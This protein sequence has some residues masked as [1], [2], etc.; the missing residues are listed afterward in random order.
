MVTMTDFYVGQLLDA[1]ELLDLADSTIVVF[2]SDHGFQLNEHGG[3]W[4]KTVQFEE[5]TRVPLLVRLPGGGQAGEVAAGL[6]ELVDLYP[7]LVE[8]CNLPAPAH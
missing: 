5:S 7:T 1:L 6:V 4:R 8:L 3:L 2:T